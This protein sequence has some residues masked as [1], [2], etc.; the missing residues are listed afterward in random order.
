MNTPSIG[1]IKNNGSKYKD[2][3]GRYLWFSGYQGHDG[4]ISRL[5]P[6]SSQNIKVSFSRGSQPYA[7]TVSF[8]ESQLNSL[9]SGKKI[10]N[11]SDGR[12]YQLDSVWRKSNR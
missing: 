1:A 3:L 2:I 6:I 5:S 12:K 9:L 8:T 11:K 4:K 7:Y 10:T